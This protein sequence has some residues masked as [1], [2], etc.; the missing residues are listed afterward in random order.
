MARTDMVKLL[1][2]ASMIAEWNRATDNDQYDSVGL[3]LKL[4]EEESVEVL[5]EMED[6]EVNRARLAKELADLVY[7]IYGAASYF[8]IPLDEC[9][10]EVHRSNMTKTIGGVK[11]RED[12][13]IEK[14]PNYRKA[15]ILGVLEKYEDGYEI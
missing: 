1:G 7:V 9:I 10:A 15:D 13:K 2:A 11:R 8:K 6:E 4:I 3:R 14:G 12:G 5:D